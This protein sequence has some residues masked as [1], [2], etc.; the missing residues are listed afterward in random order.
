MKSVLFVKLKLAIIMDNDQ[1]VL[2]VEATIQAILDRGR[3]GVSINEAKLRAKS[4][5]TDFLLEAAEFV[6]AQP[7][8]K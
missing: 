4:D 1:K 2:D 8:Y 3:V 7:V 6:S 5:D